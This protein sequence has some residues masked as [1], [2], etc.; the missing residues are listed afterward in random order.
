[1]AYAERRDGKLTGFWYG[2]VCAQTSKSLFATRFDRFRRRFD[3][4]K[5]AEGYE[6]YVKATG[7]EPANLQDAKLSG[8]TLKETVILMLSKKKG[9]RDPSGARRLAYIV[10]RLGHLTMNAITTTVLDSLVADLEKRPSQMSGKDKISSGTINRYLSAYSG[11]LTWARERDDTLSAPVIP[12]RKEAG[13]RIHWFSQAQEDVLVPYMLGQGWL[14]EA[15]TLRVL[16]ATGMRW[17]EFAGLEPHQCQPE[18]IL[19]DETKTD[20]PRDIP[21]DVEL[22]KEL[23]AMVTSKGTPAYLLMRR[24]LKSA[25]KA[26]GYS[27]KLGLH[28]CRHSTATR[29][30]KD[31][32][33][34]P[35]VQ[36][37]LGHKSIKT[38]MKYVHVEAADLMQA[39]RNLHPRRG[40]LAQKAP[41]STVVPFMKSTG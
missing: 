16:C 8:P 10:E 25:V 7:E 22:A 37:F 14:A 41:E 6:A 20:T 4:K 24:R 12:W 38:T 21:I 27:P 35:I 33:A 11:V 9:S 1:M 5:A 26:C 31:G 39:M 13:S 19:L 23:K 29:L 17:G 34:L 30:I 32:A 18:W 3:T 28:N 2:E 40:E 15:L 36:K